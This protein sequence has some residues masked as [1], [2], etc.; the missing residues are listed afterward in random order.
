MIGLG[1]EPT[2]Y[3]CGIWKNPSLDGD[4]G[5]DSQTLVRREDLPSDE[6]DRIEEV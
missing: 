6:E 2:E 3:G 1:F 5:L 4:A